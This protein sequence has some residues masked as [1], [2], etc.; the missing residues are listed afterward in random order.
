[1]NILE[2]ISYIL[3]LLAVVMAFQQPDI[4]RYVASVGAAGIAIVRLRERYEGSNLRLKRLVRLR[5]LVG[6]IYVVGAGLMF[7]PY[8][9]WLVAFFIAVMIEL[10]TILV[11]ERESKKEDK[12]DKESKLK[13]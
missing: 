2:R 12:N 6:I 3:V 8:N 13:K 1:M 9:Y 10:Y 4:A 7:R 11:A 5:H